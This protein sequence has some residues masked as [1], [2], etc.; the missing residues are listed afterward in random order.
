MAK[1]KWL[2]M[3]RVMDELGTYRSSLDLWRADG[4]MDGRTML[5]NSQLHFD[6]ARTDGLMERL[7]V[8]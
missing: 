7:V 8:E 6:R 5:P 1:K 3:A 2:T 4:R